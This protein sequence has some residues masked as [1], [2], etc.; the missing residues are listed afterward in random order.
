MTKLKLKSSIRRFK[1]FI[2]IG[3]VFKCLMSVNTQT[4]IFLYFLFQFQWYLLKSKSRKHFWNFIPK[5]IINGPSETLCIPIIVYNVLYTKC[6]MWISNLKIPLN[7]LAIELIIP[8]FLYRGIIFK[9]KH[10]FCQNYLLISN[11]LKTFSYV[12]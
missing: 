10:S 7:F 8:I 11:I 12:I 9:L 4:M 6:E 3:S 5:T 1:E 2:K